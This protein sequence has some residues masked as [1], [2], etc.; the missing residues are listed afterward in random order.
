M[1]GCVPLMLDKLAFREATDMAAGAHLRFGEWR[2]TIGAAERGFG[3]RRDAA[4]AF[5]K[6]HGEPAFTRPV[7][8]LA[9]HAQFERDR[10]CGDELLVGFLRP[11]AMAANAGFDCRH[12]GF[13]LFAGRFDQSGVAVVD[14]Y[15]PEI[16]SQNLPDERLFVGSRC[17]IGGSR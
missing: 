1:T 5:R 7:A 10:R 14:E 13:G 4:P 16:E 3:F 8:S 17:R 15:L 9:R 2:A 11:S 12:S 6:M